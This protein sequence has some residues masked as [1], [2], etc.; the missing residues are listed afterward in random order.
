[1]RT[2]FLP[3]FLLFFAWQ[4][5]AQILFCLDKKQT[6]LSVSG[7][8]NKNESFYTLSIARGIHFNLLGLL[9]DDITVFLDVTDKSNFLNDNAFRVTYGAQ[10][11]LYSIR[12]FKIPFRKTFT[13]TRFNSPDYQATYVGAEFELMPGRYT[14]THFIALDIYYGDN[15]RGRV[16]STDP[17]K[18]VVKDVGNGW[19]IPRLATFRLGL[20]M[21]YYLKHNIC[22]YGNLDLFVFRPKESELVY[23]PSFPRLFG[24]VGVNYLF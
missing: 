18:Q 14:N 20:N 6:A 23:Y 3:L 13:I 10:G 4:L 17:T 5:Q 22:L 8:I 24:F 7:G 1:M 2:R 9:K 19:F 21:G 12:R 16:S 11:S 15:F